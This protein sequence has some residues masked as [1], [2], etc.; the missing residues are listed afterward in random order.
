VKII[1]TTVSPVNDF[2]NFVCDTPYRQVQNTNFKFTNRNTQP[3]LTGDYYIL[4]FNFDLRNSDKKTSAFKY[5]YSSYTNTGDAIFLRNS[6]TILLK[7]GAAALSNWVAADVPQSNKL[8]V[9][10]YNVMYNPSTK[11]SN[12][13]SVITAYAVYMAT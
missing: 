2:G 12:S 9:M 13:E 3:L 1:P 8:N 10:L 7:V 4:K 5:P 11:L 6:K